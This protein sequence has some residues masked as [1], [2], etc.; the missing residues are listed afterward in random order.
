MKYLSYRRVSKNE[1]DTGS[2]S[3][4]WQ[5][6]EIKRWCERYKVKEIQ[7][8]FDDG[9]TARKPL[10]KRPGGKELLE[11]ANGG[12]CTVVCA[13][14]DRIFRSTREFLNQTFEWASKGI[15]FVAVNGGV[16]LV[17]A[18]GRCFATCMAAFHQLEREKTSERSLSRGAQRKRSGMRHCA[19]APYGF[20]WDGITTDDDGKK[21]GGVPVRDEIEQQWISK[22]REW[23][24]KGWSFRRIADELNSLQVPTRKGK[25]W[26]FTSVRKIL[27]TAKARLSKRKREDGKGHAAPDL[28][29]YLPHD[30]EEAAE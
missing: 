22:M 11:R 27:T 5:A 19:Y 23:Q 10:G 18:E 12:P 24:A 21:S 15:L 26:I 20:R 1:R 25:P 28:N 6:A 13:H 29:V 2:V 3:L 4:E 8:S 17:T 16:D 14:M 30:L 7:D 9:V